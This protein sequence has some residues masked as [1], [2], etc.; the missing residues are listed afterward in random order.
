MVLDAEGIPRASFE[1]IMLSTCVHAL[2]TIKL[3][4]GIDVYS[5][6]LEEAGV[7][8]GAY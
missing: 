5:I 3:S 1:V 4:S 8:Q 2:T 6:V 7:E